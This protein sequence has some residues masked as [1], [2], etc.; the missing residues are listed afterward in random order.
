MQGKDNLKIVFTNIGKRNFYL[1]TVALIARVRIV[2]WDLTK[3]IS[4]LKVY[5]TCILCMFLFP[6]NLHVVF[7]ITYQQS[8]KNTPWIYT[9]KNVKIFY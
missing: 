3:L 5:K 8:N 2:E 1:F 9:G 7:P 6:Y 4:A